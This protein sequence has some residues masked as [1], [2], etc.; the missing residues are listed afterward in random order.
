[1]VKLVVIGAGNMGGALLRGIVRSGFLPASSLLASSPNSVKLARLRAELSIEVRSN[2]AQAV[3]GTDC[4]ILA[5]KPY[6]I[7]QVCQEVQYSLSSDCLVI[8][9]AAGVQLATIQ[10]ALPGRR[11]LRALPNTP[12]AIAKGVTCWYAES[13]LSAEQVAFAEGLFTAVGYQLRV[14]SELQ[15][16]L[17]GGLTG[18]GPAFFY[19]YYE[20]LL[21]AAVHIGLPREMSNQLL[22]PCLSGCL[23]Y[24]CE[25]HAHPAVLRNEVT[26]PAGTTTAGLLELEAGGVRAAITRSL[27]A[28]IERSH[29]LAR[30]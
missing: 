19:H 2:N 26:S 28:T 23:D 9:V 18:A 16:T 10:M 29:A 20:A 24:L 3:A 15:L 17:A 13:D 27:V 11:V 5:V 7:E 14:S 22:S 21:D 6:L 8:S 4:V 30:S 12:C 25:R 1:M